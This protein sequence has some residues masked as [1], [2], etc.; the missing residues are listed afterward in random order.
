[1]LLNFAASAQQY[2]IST[3]AGGG[4]A[5]VK[6]IP[7][8][9]ASLSQPAVIA[10]DTS[11]NLYFANG[12]AVFKL[13]ANAAVTRIAGTGVAGFSGDGGLAVK[14]RLQI[15]IPGQLF[16]QGLAVDR[17]GDVFIGDIGNHRIRKVSPGG[18]IT[19]VAGSGVSGP[20]G[21]GGPAIEAQ[22][23]QPSGLA[24]DASGNLFIS[25]LTNNVVR[26]V[27]ASGIISTVAGIASLDPGFAGDGG[28]A[29]S[30]KLAIPWTIA[31]DLDGNLFI[32]DLLNDRV[33]KVSPDG[34]ISTVVG[35]GAII[36]GPTG[37]AVD[38][39]GNL[40]IADANSQVIVKV[41][42]SGMLT[43]VAGTGSLGFSG[44]GGPAIKAQLNAPWGV[45]LDGRN[46]LFI[47]DYGNQRIREVLASGTISTVAGGGAL[48]LLAV[49]G[50]TAIATNAQ[51]KLAVSG[52][53]VQSGIATDVNGNVF[54]AETGSGLIRKISSG[55]SITT[56]AGGGSCSSQN[57]CP[58]GDGGPATSAH[59]NYPTGVAVDGK[60]NLFIAEF[61]GFR[62]RMVAPDGIITTVAG[63]GTDGSSG[64]GGLATDA[65]IFA[66]GVAVDSAG[67]LF[68]ADGNRVRKVSPDGIITTVAG[69][70]ACAGPSCDGGPASN[71]YLGAA[72]VAVDAT[73]NLLIADNF[74][75]D[76]G[77]YVYI[78]KVSAGIITT[79]AGMAGPCEAAGDGGPAIAAALNYS[80]SIAVDGA[81]NLFLADFNG[82]RI[83]RI[84]PDGIISTV[85]GGQNGYSGD[86]GPAVN[87]AVNYPIAVATDAAGHVF[88]SDAFNEV[89]RILRP[90]THPLLSAV[91]DAASQRPDPVTPGKIV[92]IYGAALGP[93]S[94]VQNQPGTVPGGVGFGTA[95]GGTTVTF[96]SISAPVLYAS[97]TQVA[98]VVPYEVSGATAQVQVAYLGDV[99]NTFAMPTA[100]TAP[101]F[102]TL[103]RSGTG[104]AAAINAS[105]GKPNTAANPVKIGESITLYA[106]GEGQT[107]RAGVDGKLADFTS[108][109]PAL[110]VTVTVGGIPASVQYAGGAPGQ[111]AGLMQI[112]VQIP[113]GVQP[114]GYVPVVLQVG[115][116]SS[117]PDAVWIAVSGK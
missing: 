81:G 79:L 46:N 53:A 49:D 110:P 54:F 65:Q 20:S 4:I 10:V 58:S 28:P 99:S 40:F 11:G 113:G 35:D 75:D 69:G 67:D 111:V 86:G 13:D 21:D 74:A 97:A 112:N 98:V 80:S 115:A 24:I 90:I 94:L 5:P 45:A 7:A 89:I 62:V 105:N 71:A 38:D 14:A 96:N 23:G 50:D 92:V 1:V 52:L 33:R 37:L 77:C 101:S 43:Y 31:L 100:A 30:A 22:L 70:G 114:G 78:R 18:I 25:D 17:D 61:S 87:A 66:W 39:Q 108:I 82:Q 51:L 93:A 64:D 104:Q 102:F 72:A 55:G 8:L 9:Q 88:F 41:T 73:G 19:T 15:S 26:K 85:A 36:R 117:A 3:Y 12:N 57:V 84:S 48:D 103:N 16:A 83:R 95:V 63:N 68:I 106:T 76:S 56:V 2:A 60:G 29:T 109:H 47:S 32:A 116:A 44:D 42:P 34:T 6:S 27:S 107:I 59:L 91:L